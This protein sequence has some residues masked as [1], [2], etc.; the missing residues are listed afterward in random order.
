LDFEQAVT[1]LKKLPKP[2]EMNH[3]RSLGVSQVVLG[4]WSALES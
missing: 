2:K 4:M 1:K 3:F